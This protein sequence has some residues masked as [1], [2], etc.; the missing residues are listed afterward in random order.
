MPKFS[1]LNFIEEREN[2]QKISQQKWT[3]EKATN[4]SCQIN[5]HKDDYLCG[6]NRMGVIIGEYAK[7]QGQLQ[8]EFHFSPKDLKI[9]SDKSINLDSSQA[10]I[11][12]FTS[13]LREKLDLFPEFHQCGIDYANTCVTPDDIRKTGSPYYAGERLKQSYKEN[14][15]YLEQAQQDNAKKDILFYTQE[16]DKI[17]TQMNDR[18]GLI[19]R[20]NEIFHN[21][22]NRGFF[23]NSASI[24]ENGYI[25]VGGVI[26]NPIGETIESEMATLR[27]ASNEAIYSCLNPQSYTGNRRL[28]FF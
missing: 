8:F 21:S 4:K 12:K 2:Q 26:L 28:Q 11:H 6:Y 23:F 19:Q 1:S 15:K 27:K 5:E 18:N 7:Y 17:Q 20:W 22:M 10:E 3:L 13:C 25:H 16:L 14:K 24:H 9:D